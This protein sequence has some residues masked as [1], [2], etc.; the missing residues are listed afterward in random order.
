MHAQSARGGHTTHAQLFASCHREPTTYDG[1]LVSVSVFFLCHFAFV[2]SIRPGVMAEVPAGLSQVP[3]GRLVS[4]SSY[5]HTTLRP[6]HRGRPARTVTGRLHQAVSLEKKLR[7]SWHCGQPA[8]D[9]PASCA[10]AHCASGEC[11]L[12]SCSSEQ[13]ASHSRTPHRVKGRSYCAA[14]AAHC[15]LF[16]T[17]YA[18]SCYAT[19]SAAVQ[20]LSPPMSHPSQAVKQAPHPILSWEPS[21]EPQRRSQSG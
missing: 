13:T 11:I 3:Q 12:P 4:C 15:S 14:Q 7:R 1:S 5:S 8:L 17:V 2:P 18:I 21:R 10:C 20:Q 9:E 19:S 16:S 6:A